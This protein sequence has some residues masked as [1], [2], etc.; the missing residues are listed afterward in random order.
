MAISIPEA[1]NILGSDAEGLSDDEIQRILTS[2]YV[3]AKDLLDG[4]DDEN[5]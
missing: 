4:S 1:R 2:L 3:L 5:L